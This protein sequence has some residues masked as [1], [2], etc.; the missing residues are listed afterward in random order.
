M[1]SAAATRWGPADDRSDGGAYGEEV[2]RALQRTPSGATGPV[3]LPPELITD[4]F[5]SSG[6][7]TAAAS[8]RKRLDKTEPVARRAQVDT[9]LDYIRH[10][11]LHEKRAG[12]GPL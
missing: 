3:E 2:R 5:Q 10:H 9:L 12:D 1:P 4:H 6:F 11:Q 7:A 8:T